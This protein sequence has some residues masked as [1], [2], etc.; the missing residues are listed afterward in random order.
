[1]KPLM[2]E[3]LRELIFA[4]QIDMWFWGNTHYCA[5]FDRS[6]QTPFIGSC[7]GHGGYPYSRLEPNPIQPAPLAWAEFGSRYGDTGV[8]SDRGNNGYCVFEFESDGSTVLRY[9]DWRGYE[10]FKIGLVKAPGQPNLTLKPI[11]S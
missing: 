1:M 8:R 11:V 10:R 4:N 5:L 9:I 7:I 6:V 3:D 2:L